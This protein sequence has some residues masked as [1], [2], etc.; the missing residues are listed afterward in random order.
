MMARKTTELL[1]VV[2]LSASSILAAG[3][4]SS[5]AFERAAKIFESR[6]TSCHGGAEPEKGLNLERHAIYRSTINK[7]ARSDRRKLLISPNRVAESYLY[8][9]LLPKAQGDYRGPRMPL[10]HDPLPDSELAQIVSWIESFPTQQW[11]EPTTLQASS[12]PRSAPAE[13]HSTH[14]TNLPTAATVPA[15]NLEFRFLH[16]FRPSVDAAGSKGLW[17]LDGGANV[18]LGLSYGLGE[19]W[20]L[21]LR[22]TNVDRQWELY[23]KWA[24][25]RQR[26][27]GAPISLAIVAGGARDG[28]DSNAFDTHYHAGAIVQRA[29]GRHLAVELVPLYVTRTNIQDPADD[30]ATSSIG[31]GALW[32]VNDVVGVTVEWVPQLSGPKAKYQGA[33]LGFSIGTARHSFHIVLTNTP[34]AHPSQYIP[35]ADLDWG[36]GDFR[37]GFNITRTF[38]LRSGRL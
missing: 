26:P 30:R 28:E 31:V 10:H 24:A 20:E 2:L 5:P 12:T 33:S 13:F 35:G 3:E 17:G 38:G 16:R 9:R 4:A 21:G 6:C 7:P 36:E 8:Q 22:R 14:L 37:L 34:Y 15:E 11:G 1:L 27:G 19:R 25:L 18:S 32:R 23:G 29:F